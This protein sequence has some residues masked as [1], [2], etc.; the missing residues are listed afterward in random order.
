M[1]QARQ[2]DKQTDPE[3]ERA[4]MS[5]GRL[6]WNLGRSRPDDEEIPREDDDG[7]HSDGP[8]DRSRQKWEVLGTQAKRD[9]EHGDTHQQAA[10]FRVSKVSR[11][12]FVEAVGQP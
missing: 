9:G 5:E 1:K 10:Q 8:N 3:N 7:Q 2:A 12:A 4:L 11:R 6:D